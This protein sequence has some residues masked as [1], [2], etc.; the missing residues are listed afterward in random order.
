MSPIGV[1]LAA[2]GRPGYINLGHSVDVGDTT[3]EAMEAH[4]HQVLDAAY[5]GGVRYFDAARSYGR[6]EAFL[7][8]G[9]EPSDERIREAIRLAALFEEWVGQEPGWEVVAPRPFSLVCFR[10]DGT[11]EENEAIM[12]AVNEGG[13]AFL[14]HTRL[15]GR[16]V[17]RLAVGNA[18]T[19]ED[20]VRGAWD[21]LRRAAG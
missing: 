6:G 9:A 1:G 18:R 16:F 21:A 15:D 2:L 17:L 11:D 3:V 12:R 7:A 14:S 4:A 10:R 19:T 8:S 5:E 13:E 20:D